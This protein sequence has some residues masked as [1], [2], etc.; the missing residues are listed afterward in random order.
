MA[1]RRMFTTKIVES[2]PFTEMPLSAQALY[3][4]LNMAADDDGFINNPQKI[5]RSIEASEEDLETL[6]QKR[7]VLTFENG[8]ILIKHWRMHN[9]IRKDRYKPTQYQEQLSRL[10]V[11]SDG[12]YTEKQPFMTI[13]SENENFGNQS[14]TNRQ[15]SDNQVTTNGQPSDNQWLPQDSIGKVSIEKDSIVEKKKRKKKETPKA[16]EKHKR[17]E[18]QHVLLTDDEEE[19]LIDEYG[20]VFALKAITFLDEYIEETGYERKNHYLC[21][22]RWV[23]DAV[24]EKEEKAIKKA[25]TTKTR[26]GDFDPEEAFQLALQRSYGTETKTA[27]NDDSV[28]ERMEALKEKIGQGG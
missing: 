21:I 17:G 4:H 19:K 15:P 13:E 14:V 24:K 26:Y 10:Q 16:P 18:Y 7:F 9:S 8:L 28:R 20:M 3:F 12:A 22:K 1:E 5:R 27:A 11:R 23:I 6:V 25:G 2:D